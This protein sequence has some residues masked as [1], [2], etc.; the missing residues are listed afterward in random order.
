MED[1]KRER[2]RGE[3]ENEKKEREKGEEGVNGNKKKINTKMEG[4][5]R[6]ITQ[7]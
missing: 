7:G 1:E 2:K 6:V 4:E 3:M 5:E